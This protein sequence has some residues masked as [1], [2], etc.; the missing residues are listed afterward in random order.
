MHMKPLTDRQHTLLMTL[1]D[2]YVR[3][4][5]PV[6]SQNLAGKGNLQVSP[7]TIRNELMELEEAGYLS[8]PYT[9]AGRIP[10]E[11]AWRA[12]ITEIQQRMADAPARHS[13]ADAEKLREV[14][15]DQQRTDVE[16]L[17]K[18]TA[19][20]LAELLDE[21][22]IVGFS[23]RD[24]Y[25][26]GLSHLFRQPEFLEIRDVIEISALVDR[27]D[28]IVE[29]VFTR[30]SQDPAVLLGSENP[31]GE[32][33]SL[34]VTAYDVPHQHAHGVVAALGPVRQPYGEH[35]SLLQYATDLLRAA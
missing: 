35:L 16:T 1:I 5:T 33:C 17:L 28:E 23:P 12:Y 27:L 13:A 24:V 7:A 22:I 30:A 21:A 34:I 20:M 14:V 3:S 11:R 19:K 6:A 4:A 18:E 2:E 8:Q 31:L 32:S 25:T 15:H 9:S 10:T 26:T 29:R